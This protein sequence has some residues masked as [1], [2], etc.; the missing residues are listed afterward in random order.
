MKSLKK[1]GTKDS[2]MGSPRG[3]MSP[4][5]GA[6]RAGHSDTLLS[7]ADA[8]QQ[9]P[10]PTAATADGSGMMSIISAAVRTVTAGRRQSQKCV[11]GAASQA[12]E[13]KPASTAIQASSG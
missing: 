2:P 5:G 7:D 10:P 1:K 12:A 4:N 9:Q 13:P 11:L 6:V 3:G 8:L